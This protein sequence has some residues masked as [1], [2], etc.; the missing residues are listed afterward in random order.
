[1]ACE[2][3][4][5]SQ[6]EHEGPGIIAD[7]EAL[8]RLVYHDECIR[9][10][11]SLEPARFSKSDFERKP[12]EG[13]PERGFSTNRAAHANDEILSKKARDHQTRAKEAN[14]RREVWTYAAGVETLRGLRSNDGER[15][16]CV[17][18]RAE[19]DD[20]SHA[21]LWGARPGRTNSQLRLIRDQVL[22]SLKKERRILG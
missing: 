13:V 18:D 20:H 8:L 2:C 1:M 10:D 17:V 22:A 19:A 21:E 7:G 12:P 4:A 3:E 5:A 15:S 9:A 14:D 16:I 6:S 11:G